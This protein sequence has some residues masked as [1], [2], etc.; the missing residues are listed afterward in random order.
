VPVQQL[1]EAQHFLKCETF[2][3]KE[4]ARP[5]LAF[6]PLVSASIRETFNLEGM[7]LMSMAEENA[8][9]F[10]VLRTRAQN[11]FERLTQ[12]LPESPRRNLYAGA[13]G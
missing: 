2:V 4:L 9:V 13:I 12:Y 6:G 7:T 11:T 5:S 3:M 10:H 1:K 8:A